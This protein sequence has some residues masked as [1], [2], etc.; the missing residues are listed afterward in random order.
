MWL[1]AHAIVENPPNRFDFGIRNRCRM[2]SIGHE[3][4][5]SWR[6]QDLE[7]MVESAIQKYVARKQRH[8]QRL[9]PIFPMMC[10]FAQRKKRLEPLVGEN[11]RDYLLVLMASVDRIPWSPTKMDLVRCCWLRKHS[12]AL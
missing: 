3:S 11:L 5:D 12:S 8:R 7:T 9:G 1:D 10:G 2:A 4:V 6:C